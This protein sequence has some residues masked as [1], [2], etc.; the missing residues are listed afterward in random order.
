MRYRC[1]WVSRRVTHESRAALQMKDVAYARGIAILPT[2]KHRKCDST[3]MLVHYSGENAAIVIVCCVEVLGLEEKS[4]V[5][6]SLVPRPSH[7]K[8]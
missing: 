5:G 2:D 6:P 7:R 8:L 1:M 3:I 4:G